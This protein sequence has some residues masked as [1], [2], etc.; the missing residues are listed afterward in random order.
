MNPISIRAANPADLPVIEAIERRCFSP[1]RRFSRDSLQHSL[2]SPAQ[3]V[4]VAIG[5]LN[6]RRQIAGVMILRRYHYSIRIM[7]LAVVPAF[8]GSGIGRKLVQR[9]V[10]L[11]RRTGFDCL[12]LEAD[13]R[14][15][16]LTGWYE[17][18]GFQAC[19]R[20]NDYYSPGRHAVRMRLKLKGARRGHS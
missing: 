17:G 4:W 2:R 13:R 3:S 12:I 1:C 14:N 10:L 19:Q 6:G 7:S 20:L 11:A 15:S 5:R 8:R 9:A 18:F 16:V